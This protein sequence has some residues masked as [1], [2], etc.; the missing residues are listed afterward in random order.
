MRARCAVCG[1]SWQIGEGHACPPKSRQNGVD[2]FVHPPPEAEALA[3][4]GLFESVGAIEFGVTVK[5]EATGRCDY[6]VLTGEGLRGFLPGL[7]KQNA[8]ARESVIVRPEGERVCF[9]QV[10]DAP[11]ET[12][13]LLR[14]VAFGT[15]ET[16]PGSNQPWLAVTDELRADEL[17]AARKRFLARVAETGGNGGSYGALRWPGTLNRKHDPAPLVRVVHSNLG[18]TTTLTELEGLGLLALPTLPGEKAASNVV[19]FAGAARSWP[20]YEKALADAPRKANGRPDRSAADFSFAQLSFL[21]GKSY[22]EVRA[23]LLEVSESARTKTE[24]YLERTLDRAQEA[25]R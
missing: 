24:H 9:W 25:A 6:D 5:D 10:D 4:V 1:E 18:R 14:G 16:S 22:C 23:K 11:Q 2:T 3:A 20:S 17:E 7:L 12:A 8:A 19:D 15:I 21:R 13:D